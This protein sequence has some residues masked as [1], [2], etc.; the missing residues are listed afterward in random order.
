MLQLYL[1]GSVLIG[2]QDMSFKD[3]IIPQLSTTQIYTDMSI[4]P[5]EPQSSTASSIYRNISITEPQSF[6]TQIYTDNISIT[7]DQHSAERSILEQVINLNIYKL[8]GF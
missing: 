6:T 7:T 3:I 2:S 1:I 4:I 5:T 8:D